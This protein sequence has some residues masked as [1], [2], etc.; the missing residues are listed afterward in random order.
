MFKIDHNKYPMPKKLRHHTS[1]NLYMPL[2]E[3]KEIPEHYPPV[4]DKIDFSGFF[5]NGKAPD[6]LDIGCG[7]GQFLL[8]FAHDNPD[9][10]VMGIEIRN[11][12]V[13]WINEVISGED[14]PNARA[15]FYSV[16]NGLPFIGDGTVR[17]I[18]YLFPDPWPKLRHHR[19]R[20]FNVRSLEECHRVL[21]PGGRL[22]LATDVDHV[23]AHHLKTLGEH[24]GFSCA[25][26][27]SREEWP[28]PV[29]NKEKFCLLNNIQVFRLLCTK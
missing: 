7:K 3:L 25:R 19:R 5:P 2:S 18:F 27:E 8:N 12:A 20:A 15:L 17:D 6:T 13:K 9:R 10:T 14:Y 23:D 1:A 16:A 26:I 11:T 21:A 4:I 22:W 24:G 28:L 29:T